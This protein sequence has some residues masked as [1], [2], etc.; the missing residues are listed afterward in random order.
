[1]KYRITLVFFAFLLVSMNPI[2]GQISNP[3]GG[4]QPASDDDIWAKTLEGNHYNEMWNYQFYLNDGIA[5]HIA[6]SVANFGSFKSPVSGVQMS[7]YNLDGELYQ[8]TREYPIHYLIQDKDEYMFQLRDERRIYFRGKLPGEHEVRVGFTKD[9]ISYDVQLYLS[10]IHRGLK[11]GDGIFH[12]GSEEIGVITH[13]PYA[14]V[15][16]TIKVNNTEKKVHGTAYMDHTY[17]DQATTDL[18][19]SGYRFVHQSDKQNWDLLYFFLPEKTNKNKTIGYRLTKNE[20]E[21]SVDGVEYIDRLNTAEAFGEDVARILDLRLDDSSEI[22]VSRTAD[23]EKFS[24]LGELGWLAK[25][26]AKSFLGGEVI[27]LRGEAILMESGSRPKRGHYN[28]FL[29]D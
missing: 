1:M 7:I 6:Y 2:F 23:L 10:D 14:K 28:F 20:G 18:V 19:H 9:D 4:V 24:V 21:L 13:I 11:W 16:G 25:K 5:V 8:V 12:I 22:R 3:E 29:I 15:R 27:Y 26:A 17:Q